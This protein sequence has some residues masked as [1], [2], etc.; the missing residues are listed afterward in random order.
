MLAWQPSLES[1]RNKSLHG[2]T[3]WV[4]FTNSNT[5]ENVSGNH[6]YNKDFPHLKAHVYGDTDT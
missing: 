4:G 3:Q 2:S 6:N 1:N 5:A